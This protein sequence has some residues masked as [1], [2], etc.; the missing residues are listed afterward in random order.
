MIWVR[1]RMVPDDALTVSVLDRTFEH[2]L[3]L[4]E[5]LCT[6]DGR[7]PLLDRHLAR[8]TRSAREL[9]IPLDE[10]DLPDANAVAALLEA[11]GEPGDRMLRMT[12]SGGLSDAGGSRLWM[13]SAPLPPPIGHGGAVVDVGPWRVV[14]HDPLARHKALNYWSRRLAYESTRRLGFDEVL[15]V[16]PGSTIWEGS[17]TN[18]F[19]L[20]GSTLT[21]PSK[22][23]PIV[24]GVMRGL[25][26]ELADRI[27]LRPQETEGLGRKDLA[28][29]DEVFLTNSVRGIIPVARVMESEH[30]HKVGEWPGPGRW[31]KDLMLLVSDRLKR[32]GRE[33]T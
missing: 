4:F 6:R 18:V 3:G 7:A 22:E 17:R 25:V 23:G 27:P 28:S 15:S 30:R 1:G 21:T 14:R 5:T 2:G 13:R 12:L 32:M 11:E 16:A 20:H 19:V 26:L 29:A 10:A 31:T 8:L 24:P 33:A 9:S